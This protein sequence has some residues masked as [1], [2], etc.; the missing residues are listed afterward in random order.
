[1]TSDGNSKLKIPDSAETCSPCLQ[2]EKEHHNR[3]SFKFIKICSFSLH[4]QIR[5]FI[6][7]KIN[8]IDKNPVIEKTAANPEHYVFSSARNYADLDNKLDI[9]TVL[10]F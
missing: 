7:Q 2:I 4:L 1:M 6:K 9:I 3:C 10:M 5:T 8:Y